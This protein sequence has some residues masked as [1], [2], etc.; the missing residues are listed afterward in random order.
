MAFCSSQLPLGCQ[1]RRSR[2]TSTLP[3][4]QNAKQST[5]TASSSS[6]Q[7][8]SSFYHPGQ[9][10]GGDNYQPV[11]RCTF[12]AVMEIERKKRKASYSSSVPSKLPNSA[13]KRP[14][15]TRSSS[16]QQNEQNCESLSDGHPA[17]YSFSTGGFNILLSACDYGRVHSSRKNN[18]NFKAIKMDAR[19]KSSRASAHKKTHGSQCNSTNLSRSRNCQNPALHPEIFLD[20]IQRYSAP[21]SAQYE[22]SMCSSGIFTLSR[23]LTVE[24]IKQ[25]PC[26]CIDPKRKGCPYM[27]SDHMKLTHPSPQYPQFGDTAFTCPSCMKKHS[28]PGPCHSCSRRPSEPVLLSIPWRSSKLVTGLVPDGVHGSRCVIY[29]RER[30]PSFPTSVCT[31]SQSNKDD[32][33]SILPFANVSE[34]LHQIRV[35][36]NKFSSITDNPPIL[37]IKGLKPGVSR[38]DDLQSSR[39]SKYSV[40]HSACLMRLGERSDR[41]KMLSEKVPLSPPIKTE[42]VPPLLKKLSSE[43]NQSGPVGS[44]V[45]GIGSIPKDLANFVMPSMPLQ[46]CSSRSL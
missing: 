41:R 10:V 15:H 28:R 27:N 8:K 24:E 6:Q 25:I 20:R 45:A 14:N 30:E 16:L 1:L 32:S 17:L 23:I 21:V 37:C 12:P 46:R 34:V 7:A 11:E 22:K 39:S 18:S 3:A 40:A 19:R 43:E 35:A 44:K 26:P 13:E 36:S 2:S 9:L 5:N 42:E 33:I 29:H 31:P 4:L 38:S